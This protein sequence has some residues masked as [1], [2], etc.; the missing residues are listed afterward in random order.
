MEAR[1][2]CSV[3]LTLS[4]P[5]PCKSLSSCHSSSCRASCTSWAAGPSGVGLGSLPGPLPTLLALFCM[6]ASER[7]GADSKEALSKVFWA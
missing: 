3:H 7:P 5:S 4:S 2:T 6:G 1:G